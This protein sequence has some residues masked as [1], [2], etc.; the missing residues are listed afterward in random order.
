VIVVI[1]P[2]TGWVTRRIDMTGLL[3]DE[4]R[5]D[6]NVDVLNGIAWDDENQRLFVTGKLWPVVYHI[7][8][9]QTGS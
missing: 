1:D 9:R 8:V 6:R 7:E 2:E 5:D 4:D 3:T